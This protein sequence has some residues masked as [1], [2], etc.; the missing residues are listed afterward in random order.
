VTAKAYAA[1]LD[2]NLRD[3]YERLRSG[4]YKAPPVVRVWLDKED[5]SKRPIG[6]KSAWKKDPPRA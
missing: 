4:R 1:N 2:E 3:L 6:W 5:G